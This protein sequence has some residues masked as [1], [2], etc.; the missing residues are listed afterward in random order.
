MKNREWEMEQG[1]PIFG[2]RLSFTFSF[3]RSGFICPV[4]KNESVTRLQRISARN[5]YAKIDTRRKI[6]RLAVRLLIFCK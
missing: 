1:K 5:D 6:D 3:T 2:I 4:V